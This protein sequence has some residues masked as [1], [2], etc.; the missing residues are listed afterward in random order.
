MNNKTATGMVEDAS[1]L[2]IGGAGGIGFATASCYAREGARVMI[3]DLDQA[4][5]EEGVEKLRAA[6]AQAESVV[7]DVMDTESVAAAVAAT[8][9]A[10]GR[11]DCAF[12]CAG[13]D[14]TGEPVADVSEEN[15]LRMIDLK[16]NGVWRGVRAQLEQMQRQGRGS[17]VNM[18]GTFGLV[19]VANHA[20]YCAAAHGVLGLT[21]TVALEVASQGIRINAVCPH[22]VDAP[23]LHRMMGGAEEAKRIF[24]ELLAI[25]RVCTPDEVA[26]AVVWL[27][28]DRASFVNGTSLTIDGGGV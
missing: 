10:W 16:L 18:A 27:S 20:S 8:V 19:G 11:L 13:W 22:A 24:S 12:N 5:G 25:G 4:A 26:Q 3:A 7:T 9:K 15:W 28:S 14:G 23:M 2:I 1:T 17:I 21:K 6:G